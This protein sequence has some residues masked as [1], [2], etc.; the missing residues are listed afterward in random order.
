LLFDRGNYAPSRLSEAD[1]AQRVR[2]ERI[3][4]KSVDHVEQKVG[5]DEP[6]AE[7][8]E[9]DKAGYDAAPKSS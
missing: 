3:G 5:D 4:P 9:P 2:D 1:G 8:D 6:A 7:E